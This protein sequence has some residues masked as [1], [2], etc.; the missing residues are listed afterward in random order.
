MDRDKLQT[1]LRQQPFQPFCVYLTDGRS[2]PIRYPRM[3]LLG[4]TF[5][6]IGVFDPNETDP[7][8][9][10]TEFVPLGLIDRLELLANSPPSVA[11]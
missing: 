3:N 11:S 10:Y 5:I 7:I 2:F 1:L 4:P 8:C 9:D 6:K